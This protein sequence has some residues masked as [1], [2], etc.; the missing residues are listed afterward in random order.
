[1]TESVKREGTSHTGVIIITTPQKIISIVLGA[2]Q[3]QL[4]ISAGFHSI[5]YNK[6]YKLNFCIPNVKFKHTDKC[7][8]SYILRGQ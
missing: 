4:L 2:G 3:L 6:K 7:I 5:S 8:F 1:M